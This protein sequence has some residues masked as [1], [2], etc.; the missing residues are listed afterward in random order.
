MEPSASAAA[1]VLMEIGVVDGFKVFSCSVCGKAGKQRRDIRDHI[2]VNHAT[3]DYYCPYCGYQ[4][5]AHVYLR[6][7]VTAKHRDQHKLIRHKMNYN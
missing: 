6:N 2:E 3:S 4:F 5:R 7:H 1:D